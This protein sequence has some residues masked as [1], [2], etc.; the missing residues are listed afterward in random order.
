[1]IEP[2]IEANQKIVVIGEEIINR[3]KD[4]NKIIVYKWVVSNLIKPKFKG[5]PS[6]FWTKKI[7]PATNKTNINNGKFVNIQ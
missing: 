7:E 3:G 5:A 6:N 4:I 1:M 2:L